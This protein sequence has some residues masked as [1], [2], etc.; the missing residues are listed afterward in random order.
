MK[1]SWSA[2]LVCTIIVIS[3]YG[4][5][6]IQLKNSSS[7]KLQKYMFILFKAWLYPLISEIYSLESALS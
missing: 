1:L 7:I 6:Q 3:A 4:V 2:R 5:L